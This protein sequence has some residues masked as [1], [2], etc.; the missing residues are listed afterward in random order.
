MRD[1]KKF[2]LNADDFGLSKFNNQAVLED[3]ING[4]L[5]GASI[6]ANTP[7]FESAINDVL[8]D[9]QNLSIGVHLNIIEGKSLTKCNI[10]TNSKGEFNKGYLYFLL[11]RNNQKLLDEIEVE[12]RV[13]IE[14]VKSVAIIDHIDS[15]VHVHSIPQIFELVC[16]LAKEYNIEY[17]RTQ[18]EKPFTVPSFKKNFNFKY[19][20]NLIKL[21]LLNSLTKINKKILAKYDLKTNDYI[22]GVTYTSMMDSE[23]IKSA[24]AKIE[25]NAAVECLIHPYKS[26]SVTKEFDISKDNDLKEFIIKNGFEI[27]GFKNI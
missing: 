11:N 7:A 4:F 17:V 13:Q 26:D 22:I 8:P 23:V 9:C 24:L 16:K 12:F 5:S 6:C 10:I 15:H 2:I 27:V 1:S 25:G 14:K 19:P 21:I 20:I 18:Y 3:T